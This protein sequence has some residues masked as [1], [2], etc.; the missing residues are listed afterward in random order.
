MRNHG[1]ADQ[2]R[3]VMNPSLRSTMKYNVFQDFSFAFRLMSFISNHV[4]KVQSSVAG[5]LGPMWEATR[6]PEGQHAWRWPLVPLVI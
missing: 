1:I 3:N 5:G 6:P 2:I 4:A